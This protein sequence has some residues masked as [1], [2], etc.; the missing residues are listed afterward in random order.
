VVVG[1]G[2]NLDWP[3]P[4]DAG[5]TSL[6]LLSSTPVDRE[7]LLAVLLEGLSRRRAGLESVEG[8]ARSLDELRS[9]CVTIGQ[10]VR[11]TLAE[12]TVEGTATGLDGGG[13]LLVRVGGSQ[14]AISAGDVVHLRTVPSDSEGGL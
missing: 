11:V 6:S 9:R 8:R 4:P 10:E 14:R 5:G 1:I 2:L 12:Q 13:R 3:G 7:E